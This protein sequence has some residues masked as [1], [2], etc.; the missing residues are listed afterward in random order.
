MNMNS[1]DLQLHEQH[2]NNLR[3]L[4]EQTHLLEETR[5]PATAAPHHQ[6]LARLGR[7]L[8]TSGTYLLELSDTAHHQSPKPLTNRS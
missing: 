4:S 6:M 3:R 5:N 8:V 1:K 7:Q 2:L